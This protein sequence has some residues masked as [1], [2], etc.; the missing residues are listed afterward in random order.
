M[1]KVVALLVL[2]GVPVRVGDHGERGVELAWDGAVEEVTTL[3]DAFLV[4]LDEFGL[5]GERVEGTGRRPAEF[6]AE[7]IFAAIDIRDTATV[8]LILNNPINIRTSEIPMRG[9]LT[10][11]RAI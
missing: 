9:H 1:R 10:F 8:A 7:R 5:A 3:D 2:H 4:V 11:R 6:V